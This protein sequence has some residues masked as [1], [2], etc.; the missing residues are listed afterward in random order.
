MSVPVALVIPFL[1]VRLIANAQDVCL[2]LEAAGRFALFGLFV[3][4]AIVGWW[5]FWVG[6]LFAWRLRLA[7]RVAVGIA[8]LVGMCLVATWLAVPAGDASDH[9]LAGASAEC[10]PGWVPT[11]WPAV[12][13][14]H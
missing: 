12:L 13:P 3:L 2:E 4:L 1:F 8:A 6:V 11:W 14:H 7:W 9:A 10:G 5:L